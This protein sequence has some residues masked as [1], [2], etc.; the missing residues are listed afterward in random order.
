M[1]TSLNDYEAV[2][3]KMGYV[4]EGKNAKG[5]RVWGVNAST[6][7]R[8]PADAELFT[9]KR[10]AIEMAEALD[11]VKYQLHSLDDYEFQ[12]VPV[13]ITTTV[14]IDYYAAPD[15]VKK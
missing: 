14:T 7:T 11:N 2:D 3:E 15:R 8:N 12:A 10:D 5:K 6:V 9:S 4:V 13:V 1:T